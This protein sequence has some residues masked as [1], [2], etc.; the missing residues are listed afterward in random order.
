MSDVSIRN[1]IQTAPMDSVQ[2]ITIDNGSTPVT[3]DTVSG[4]EAL[5]VSSIAHDSKPA[6]TIE[7]GQKDIRIA[8]S[9]HLF[10]IFNLTHK[11]AITVKIPPDYKGTLRLNSSS[12]AV[13]INQFHSG[14]SVEGTSGSI[15]LTVDHIVSDIRLASTSGNITLRMAETT[16]DVSW[17]LESR[18]GRHSHALRWQQ[19]S[20]NKHISQGVTGRGTHKVH[21]TT[22][23]GNIA[24]Q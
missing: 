10:R 11:P 9:N 13:K 24:I 18:S 2:V 3:V 15:E 4:L 12:G 19:S 17:T 20:K 16:P 22:R 21:I 14:L 23:S 1:N 7:R 6:F 5:E 8:A